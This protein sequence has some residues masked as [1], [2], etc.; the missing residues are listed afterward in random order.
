MAGDDINRIEAALAET[1]PLL[2]EERSWSFRD[3]LA[4]KSGLSIA[5]WGFLFGGATGQLV[6]FVDGVIAL[7]FGTAT[8]LGILFL[9]CCCRSIALGA[10]ALSSCAAPS[11]RWARVCSLY[12]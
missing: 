7:T 1:L 2:P 3:M 11:A 10:R 4:V 5:T 12:R 6:G 9:R 8:G